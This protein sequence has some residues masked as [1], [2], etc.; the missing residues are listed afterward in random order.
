MI[1]FYFSVEPV[2]API[3]QMKKLRPERLSNLFKVT[4][5]T[6]S[7]TGMPTQKDWLQ[8]WLSNPGMPLAWLTWGQTAGVCLDGSCDDVLQDR[9]DC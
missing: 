5:L 1:D 8:I 4:Q 2:F 7:R 9:R 3:Y 6:G